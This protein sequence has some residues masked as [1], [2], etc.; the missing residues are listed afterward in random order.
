MASPSKPPVRAKLPVAFAEENC[1]TVYDQMGVIDRDDHDEL[2][3]HIRM[4]HEPKAETAREQRASHTLNIPVFR[5]VDNAAENA[6]EA[7][8]T[9]WQRP[10]ALIRRKHV[11]Q[12][13]PPT[14]SLPTCDEA[15][16]WNPDRFWTCPTHNV[17]DAKVAPV[18]APALLPHA[19]RSGRGLTA[20]FWALC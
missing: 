8:P 19:R 17:T 5:L 14:K 3:S 16:V 18:L 12:L 9:R 10:T 11:P 15:H 2:L 1:L 6:S 4:Q 7:Q 13:N 20:E